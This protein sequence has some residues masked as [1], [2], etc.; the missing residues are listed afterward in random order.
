[1]SR[2]VFCGS[3]GWKHRGP[4]RKLLEGLPAE[5]VVV[6]G[7]ARGADSVAEE[8]ARTMGFEVEV[9]P[10]L[11]DQEGRGAGYRRNE[12]MLALPSVKGVFAFRCSGK[13]N[14][15]DHTVKLAKSLGIP[16]R[17]VSEK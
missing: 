9:Y 10:A 16:G 8:E 15:T 13:S 12:R 11:W 6:V 4:I 2:Y 1:M 7:G 3:R 14:G 5:A 17:V